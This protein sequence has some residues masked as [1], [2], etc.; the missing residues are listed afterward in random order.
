MKIE[1]ILTCEFI[2]LNENFEAVKYL[3]LEY[4]FRKLAVL[5]TSKQTM[6]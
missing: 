5:I 1:P 4:S 3:R 2:D 6:S